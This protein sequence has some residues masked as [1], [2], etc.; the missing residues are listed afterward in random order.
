METAQRDE[1]LGVTGA[2][3]QDENLNDLFRFAIEWFDR[4]GGK[5]FAA[6][7]VDEGSALE[8]RR[9]IIV[10]QQALAEIIRAIRT[11]T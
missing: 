3:A 5:L 4:F 9:L 11:A 1:S 8:V 10:R 7:G 2:L 6:F